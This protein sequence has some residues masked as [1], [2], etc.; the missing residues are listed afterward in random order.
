MAPVPPTSVV[1]TIRRLV[2]GLDRGIISK[3][4]LGDMQQS[5]RYRS[6]IGRGVRRRKSLFIFLLGSVHEGKCIKGQFQQP[7]LR[8]TNGCSNALINFGITSSGNTCRCRANQVGD[9][10]SSSSRDPGHLKQR[11]CLAP[12]VLRVAEPDRDPSPENVTAS[13]DSTFPRQTEKVPP[14]L[15]SPQQYLRYDPRVMFWVFW[16]VA[17]RVGL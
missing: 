1:V 7:F 8:R 4:A 9:Q 2:L 12:A 15:N 17:S 13:A 11:S 16:V 14:Y 10:R 5:P 6:F 3:S